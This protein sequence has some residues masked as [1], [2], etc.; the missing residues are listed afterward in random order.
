MNNSLSM[1]PSRIFRRAAL[2]ALVCGGSLG[3]D[4]VQAGHGG[5]GPV[6]KTLDS[7]AG[8][9]ETIF[10]LGDQGKKHC[11]ES[12]EDGCDHVL[13]Q[14]LSA[15][16]DL[17]Q[18]YLVP[19]APAPP[20]S[21]PPRSAPPRSV[22]PRSV[23]LPPVDIQPPAVRRAPQRLPAPDLPQRVQRPVQ[24]PAADAVRRPRPESPEQLRRD[25]PQPLIRQPISKPLDRS[26]NNWFQD[27]GLEPAPVQDWSQPREQSP[28]TNPLQ[29]KA[30]ASPGGFF[31]ELSDPF[32]DDSASL[33]PGAGR[34]RDEGLL[35]AV[36]VESLQPTRS[37][38]SPAAKRQPNHHAVRQVSGQLGLTPLQF[39]D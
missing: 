27:R 2:A 17:N 31:D 15:P 7:I 33:A 38:L 20:R 13:L 8:G 23:P 22:P 25:L 29:L 21:A 1:Q 34:F 3:T 4:F 39:V 24:P 30:P 11:D 18:I 14:E 5:H 9:I 6:Y 37:V 12:C 35:H 26:T 16:V 32:I 10:R 19:T 28:A 36:S